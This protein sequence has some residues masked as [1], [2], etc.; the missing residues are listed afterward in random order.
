MAKND[1]LRKIAE[2][3]ARGNIADLNVTLRE[4]AILGI[5]DDKNTEQPY[6][7]LKYYWSE[8]QCF[9]A[10]T[11]DKLRAFSAFCKKLGQMTWTD[12]YRTAGKA[13]DKV[14]FGYTTH[15]DISKLPKTAFM[16]K[17]SDDLTWF[18][19]R[20][21]QESR[22]HGFRAKSAFFLVFLDQEHEVYPRA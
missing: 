21:D 22:V 17:I 8:Y 5:D 4:A 3:Q 15:K 6:V 2:K 7:S 19:L 13:G 1:K 14:G 18:E 10:W 16:G 20:V 12:I 9:S 11:P